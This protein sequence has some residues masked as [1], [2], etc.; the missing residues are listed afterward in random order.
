MLRQISP[1]PTVRAAT[2]QEGCKE[3]AHRVYPVLHGGKRRRVAGGAK[4]PLGRARRS[5]ATHGG[6]ERDRQ[7]LSDSLFSFLA[8]AVWRPHAQRRSTLGILQPPALRSPRRVGRPLD[9]AAARHE[10]GE[11][12]RSLRQQPIGLHGRVVRLKL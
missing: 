10:P 9:L 6:T 8:P 5:R 11:G 3:P 4:R 2:R 7:T 12:E 1:T